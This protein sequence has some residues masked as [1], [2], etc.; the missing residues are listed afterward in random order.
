MRDVGRCSCGAARAAADARSGWTTGALSNSSRG[1]G[2]ARRCR[3]VR[4]SASSTGARAS[5]MARVGRARSV[6]PARWMTLIL[7]IAFVVVFIRAID[8]GGLTGPAAAN[9]A[10]SFALF[11]GATGLFVIA[12][13]S[14]APYVSDYS[15]YLPE[16]VNKTRTFWAV[17]LGCAIPAIFC[18]ILGAYLFALLPEASSTV[19][20]AGD[21]SGQWVLPVMAVSLVGSDVANAYTGML[22]L[23]SIIRCFKDVR[24]SISI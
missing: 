12:M 24:Y 4:C 1:C 19:A 13:A 18:G 14:W 23:A 10:P 17:V 8:H 20:A 3:S 2:L 15:R 5:G 22:A 9:D 16:T 21:I 7:A 6:A 11:M